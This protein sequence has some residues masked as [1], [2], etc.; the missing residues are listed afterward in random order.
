MKLF[1]EVDNIHYVR[2]VL[3]SIRC[4]IN[5]E[6]SG[7]MEHYGYAASEYRNPDDLWS[8]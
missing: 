4:I 1:L 2:F 7:L 8:Q 6:D 5:S 3:H